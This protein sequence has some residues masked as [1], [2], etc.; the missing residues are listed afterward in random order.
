MLTAQYYAQEF[1]PHWHEGFSIPVIQTGAHSY[2]YR[3]A[4]CIA[5]VG[6]GLALT[7]L[8]PRMSAHRS[9]A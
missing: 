5:G 2:R 1:A 8:R 9:V 6:V 3:G 4:K 7:R